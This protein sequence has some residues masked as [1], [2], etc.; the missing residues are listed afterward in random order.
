MVYCRGAKANH[1]YRLSVK[2]NGGGGKASYS[3]EDLSKELRAPG[4]CGAGPLVTSYR[5]I[6]WVGENFS[7]YGLDSSTGLVTDHSK[8]TKVRVQSNLCCL[9]KDKLV[10]AGAEDGHIYEYF[11]ENGKDWTLVDH[12]LASGAPLVNDREPLLNTGSHVIYTGADFHTYELWYQMISWVV[13]DHTATLHSNALPLAS[14]IHPQTHPRIVSAGG[15]GL[16]SRPSCGHCRTS[17]SATCGLEVVEEE[18]Q[19]WALE[20]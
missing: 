1:L 8:L 14:P 11:L 13:T 5:H 17:S 15:A 3:L 9:A 6:F 12:H 19:G 2:T 18:G 10:F 4:V 16:S 20:T 7:L